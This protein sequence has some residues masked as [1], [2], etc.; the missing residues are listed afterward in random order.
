MQVSCLLKKKKLIITTEKDFMRLQEMKEVK[1]SNR[2]WFY[3]SI[4]IVIDEQEKF[5]LLLEKYVNEI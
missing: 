5:N 1:E 4:S 2:K 3:K